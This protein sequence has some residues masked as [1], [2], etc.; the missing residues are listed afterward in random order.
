MIFSA[1]EN[2]VKVTREFFS[3]TLEQLFPDKKFNVTAPTGILCIP[4]IQF[5]ND[6]NRKIARLRMDWGFMMKGIVE[7]FLDDCYHIFYE[8]YNDENDQIDTLV[9]KSK[10]TFD[11]YFRLKFP[12]TVHIDLDDFYSQADEI[13]LRDKILSEIHSR[14]KTV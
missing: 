9:S 6:P 5:S 2:G 12:R 13:L 7:F 3:K 11:K 4:H 10:K 1:E 14:D 8:N